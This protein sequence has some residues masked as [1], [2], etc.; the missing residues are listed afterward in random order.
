MAYTLLAESGRPVDWPVLHQAVMPIRKRVE[1]FPVP[2][3][4]GLG[5]SVPQRLRNDLA[6]EEITQLLDLLHKK[7]EMTIYDLQTGSEVPPGGLE[8]LRERFLVE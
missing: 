2:E 8:A 6:W 1:V 4:N 5:L 7:F 3:A